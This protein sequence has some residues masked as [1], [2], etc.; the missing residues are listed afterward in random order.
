MSLY[1]QCVDCSG[2]QTASDMQWVLVNASKYSKL[3]SY[4]KQKHLFHYHIA[5]RT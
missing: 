3:S 1:S 2:G 5:I 4:V